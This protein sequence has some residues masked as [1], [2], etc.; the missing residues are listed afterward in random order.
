MTKRSGY[1][2]ISDDKK[3]LRK[4]KRESIQLLLITTDDSLIAFH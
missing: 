2:G 1:A 4:S 3:T